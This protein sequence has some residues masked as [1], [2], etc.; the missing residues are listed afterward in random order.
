M[1]N[2]FE[3]GIK[4]LGALVMSIFTMASPFCLGLFIRTDYQFISLI[5]AVGTFIETVLFAA[6]IKEVCDH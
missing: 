3:N 5:C 1:E 2:D 6:L 4:W